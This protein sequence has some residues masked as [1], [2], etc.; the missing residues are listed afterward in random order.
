MNKKPNDKFLLNLPVKAEIGDVVIYIGFVNGEEAQIEDTIIGKTKF[1][2]I[3]HVNQYGI[4]IGFHKSRLI[5]VLK[6]KSGQ[7]QLFN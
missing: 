6:S 3:T 5:K 2:Y 7:T 4:K 1:D